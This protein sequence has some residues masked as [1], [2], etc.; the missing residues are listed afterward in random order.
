MESIDESDS[1][2]ELQN[3]VDL[4]QGMLEAKEQRLKVMIIWNTCQL[5]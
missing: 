5:Y 2:E 4:L 3:Q 1:K